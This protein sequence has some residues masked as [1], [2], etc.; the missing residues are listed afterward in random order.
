MV[1]G[2]GDVRQSITDCLAMADYTPSVKSCINLDAPAY[3]MVAESYPDVAA[4]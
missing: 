4:A 2:V 1:I 3:A